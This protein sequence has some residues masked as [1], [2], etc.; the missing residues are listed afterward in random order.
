MITTDIS[1]IRLLERIKRDVHKQGLYFSLDSIEL[2]LNAYEK[3]V[4]KV[5]E[6]V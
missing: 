3:R 4:L 5:A 1:R 6:L 2:I